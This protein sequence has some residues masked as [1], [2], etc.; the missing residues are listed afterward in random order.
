MPAL[1]IAH[2]GDSAHR[3]ENTL[4]AFASAL[5]LG[6]ELVELDVQLS[7]DGAVVVIHDPSVDRTTGGS[8]RVREMTLGE[9]RRLSAGYPS[10]YG[11]AFA[12]E[13]IPTLAEVLGLVRDRARAMIE[14]KSDAV[15][16]DAEGGIEALA[17]AEVRRAGMEKDVALISFDRRALVRC[18]GLAPEIARGHVFERGNAGEFLA[19]AREAACEVVMPHKRLLS[20]DL[21]DR[22]REAGIKV[23]T[24]VVDEPDELRA[25]ARFD[26]FGIGSNRPGVLLEALRDEE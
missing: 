5:E 10:R 19:G 24:W 16:S 20:D 22:A 14:I 25:L 23:A 17:I 12:G 1:I 3:P 13:R 6:V 4:A 7:H 26:L 18:R 2:R 21:R 9:L 8:G 15:T 11:A